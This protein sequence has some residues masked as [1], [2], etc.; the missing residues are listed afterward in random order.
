MGFDVRRRLSVA[1]AVTL[2][3]AVVGFAAGAVAST[4]LQLAAR[5]MLLAIILDAVDG[6]VAREGDSSAVGPLLDSIT[7]VISF[8][9]TPSLFL[10]VALTGTYG[11]VGESSPPVIVAITLLAAVYAV[12]SVIRTAFYTTYIEGVDARP[13]IPNTL[14]VIIL[15]T[16][17]LSGI[18]SPLVLAAGAVVLS[19]LMVAPFDFPKPGART[20]IPMGVVLSVS[21]VA[22]TALGRLGPR[23]MLVVALAFL[24]LGPRYYWEGDGT[25]VE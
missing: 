20:A 23:M 9:A 1:D 19:L 7:D 18:T 14:G 16:A 22:P 25:S 12:F 21:V 13:G 5:L 10:F 2:A 4:D 3:N 15:A 8:G 11:G 24:T 17:Y 6:I